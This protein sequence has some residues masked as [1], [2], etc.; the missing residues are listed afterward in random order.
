MC[1]KKICLGFL[2][3]AVFVFFAGFIYWLLKY[4]KNFFEKNLLLTA[5]QVWEV[6]SDRALKLN[7][8]KSDLLFG[9]RQDQSSTTSVLLVKN[10]QEEVVGRVEYLLASRKIKIFAGEA[11]FEVDF[12]LTWN[13]TA[14][15]RPVNETTVL[16]SYLKLSMFGKH[17]YAIPQFGKLVSE[18]PGLSPQII[19]N[20]RSEQKLLGTVQEISSRKTIGRL[21]ILPANIPLHIRIFI[22]AV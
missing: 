22:L 4:R 3:I 10:Y 2:L 11:A 20:Y 6:V 1:P 21:L 9:I 5:D 16:A 7:L 12:P 8:L 15:L 14:N 18:R 17:Q 19:F 13:R